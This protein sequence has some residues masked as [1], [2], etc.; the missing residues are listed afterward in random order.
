MMQFKNIC[1]A[2]L[3]AVGLMAKGLI[4]HS[5]K[6]QLDRVIVAMNF[7]IGRLQLA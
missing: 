7:C 5:L 4:V 1:A 2:G 6:C 3:F